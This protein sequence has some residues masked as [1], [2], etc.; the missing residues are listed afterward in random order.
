VGDRT[1]VPWA[2]F[3]LNRL[4][5]DGESQ[6]K[7]KKLVDRCGWLIRCAAFTAVGWPKPVAHAETTAEKVRELIRTDHSTR[8]STRNNRHARRAASGLGRAWR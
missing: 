7:R 8:E 1:T 6:K 4:F 3:A 2:A 5:R